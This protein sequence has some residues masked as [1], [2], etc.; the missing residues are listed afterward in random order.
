VSSQR[1]TGQVVPPGKSKTAALRFRNRVMIACST[2]AGP[3]MEHG[4]QAPGRDCLGAL[5]NPYLGTLGVG[6]WSVKLRPSRPR[7]PLASAERHTDQSGIARGHRDPGGNTRRTAD[8]ARSAAHAAVTFSDKVD[9][10]R[11]ASDDLQ[12]TIAVHGK[13]Q[14]VGSERG[15]RLAPVPCFLEPDASVGTTSACGDRQGPIEPPARRRLLH[16]RLVGAWA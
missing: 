15:Y 16:G 1:Y 4:Q 11:A 10:L 12:H 9:R 6:P 13:L 8:Q 2:A 14:P 3:A 7:L 5:R